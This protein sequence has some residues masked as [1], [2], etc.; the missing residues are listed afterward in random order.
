MVYL[1]SG[2]AVHKEKL[3]L[4]TDRSFNFCVFKCF[5][6]DVSVTLEPCEDEE[7]EADSPDIEPGTEMD[8]GEQS[9]Q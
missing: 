1:F 8:Q 6:P 5:F 7:A 4:D 2:N 9:N 3:S